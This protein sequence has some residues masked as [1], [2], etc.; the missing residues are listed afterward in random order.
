MSLSGSSGSPSRESLPAATSTSTIVTVNSATDR[1]ENLPRDFSRLSLFSSIS[2]TSQDEQFRCEGHAEHSLSCMQH[3]LQ[4]EKLCDV[5]LIAGSNGKRVLAHRLVLS[6][7]SEY[8]SAMFTGNLRESGESEVTLTDVNGDVLQGLVNYCYTGTIE[9]R[10]DNVETLLATA[11]LMQLHEVVK[12]CSRFLAHQLHPSNC[13]GI[14]MFA[15]HQA[16]SSL[17]EEANAYTSQHFMQVIQ[18]LYI[19]LT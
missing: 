3:Y 6:A 5:T 8:F 4:A 15:E 17:L 13:L 10:E 12:A 11:C 9:I 19:H 18:V 14:A 2:T 7:A 16:C 1:N